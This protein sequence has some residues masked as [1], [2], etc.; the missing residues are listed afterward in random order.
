M[1]YCFYD[2]CSLLLKGVSLFENTDETPVLSSIT[3]SEL[4][5]I[6]TANNKDETVRAQ[7]R[8]VLRCLNENI[9]NYEMVI[10]HPSMLGALEPLDLE[11]NNDIKILASA[12]YYNTFE[13]EITFFSN[14][15]LL[16][17]FALLIFPP[18]QVSSV[19]END[20]DY[21]GY[22]ELVLKDDEIAQFYNSD[23]DF[24]VE[25]LLNQ[26][27]ILKNTNGEIFDQYKRTEKGL[28]RVGYVTFDSYQFGPTKPKDAYQ[29]IAME[30][31][32]NNQITLIGGLAG[33][34]KT[35]LALSALFHKMD[36]GEI[37]RIIVFCNPVVA[38]GA[39]KLG[40]Y[41][42]TRDEKLLGSQVGSILSSKLGDQERVLQ[43][44]EKGKLQLIPAGDA[45][46]YEV[47]PHSGV[48][49]ME[50]QNLDI[51]LLKL[52]LQ[53]ISEDSVVIVDGDRK[54]QTDM[55]MYAGESNGM[56]RM[57]KVFRGSKLFGQV[58]LKNIY[59]SQIAELADLM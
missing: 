41:P 8:T 51:V 28:Q 10:Y 21:T 12:V 5:N 45:R 3:I 20:D 13:N 55:A 23:E 25:L 58:D 22:V 48:Y 2:T 37:D 47:P 9:E 19:G 52:L 26:Y 29:Q 53:R 40:F 18:E 24:P 14:D 57:S 39:A 31:M 32:L 27:L 38:R 15:L 35:Y 36:R 44:M 50:S 7:A 1:K 17:Q 4:E 59:R 30:S 6:K 56:K 43:L 49:I 16:K 54:T 34:G 11:T 33:S 46:G 42:G